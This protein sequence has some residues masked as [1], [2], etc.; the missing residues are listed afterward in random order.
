MIDDRWPYRA[1]D[2]PAADLEHGARGLAEAGGG[3]A[4]IDGGRSQPRLREAADLERLS[5]VLADSRRPRGRGWC[6]G[7]PAP[8]GSK[9]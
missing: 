3:E 2:S 6:R 9:A 5:A 4:V 8:R 1:V 7:V